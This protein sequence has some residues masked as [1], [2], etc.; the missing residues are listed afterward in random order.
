MYWI[1]L[2]SELLLLCS[3]SDYFDDLTITSY[4]LILSPAQLIV[5]CISDLSKINAIMCSTL[6]PFQPMSVGK[7]DDLL[8]FLVH[9]NDD[10]SIEESEERKLLSLR[11]RDV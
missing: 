7:D 4:S 5:F 1:I 11:F 6:P 10:D 2:L 9:H 8:S 3:I